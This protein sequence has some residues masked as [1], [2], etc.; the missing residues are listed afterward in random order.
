MSHRARKALSFLAAAVIA[1][2][3]A[4]TLVIFNPDA[5]AG[6]PQL[7]T[8]PFASP[9]P[10]LVSSFPSTDPRPTQSPGAHRASEATTCGSSG[11]RATNGKQTWPLL[12]CAGLANVNPLPL[13]RLRPGDG[14]T[15]VNEVGPTH[16]ALHGGGVV[17]IDGL[18]L[19]ARHAGSTLVT[20]SGWP[21]CGVLQ[22]PP[23]KECPLMRI[24]VS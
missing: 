11:L 12:N 17:A 4:G 16:I 14:V 2:L 9:S 19:A 20:V 5:S 13:V 7:P 8:D 18:H 23:P 6:N 10:A 3:A 1:L 24:M 22:G 21:W 15:I